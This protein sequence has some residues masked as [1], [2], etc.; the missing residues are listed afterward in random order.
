MEV[1]IETLAS[2]EVHPSSWD[3]WMIN[4]TALAEAQMFHPPWEQRDKKYIY[5]PTASLNNLKICTIEILH[6][7]N[8]MTQDQPLH[9]DVV[10]S[11]PPSFT[12]N[13]KSEAPV[14]P[15]AHKRQW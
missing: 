1:P 10:V 3:V 11:C 8:L 4:G 5:A 2:N 6:A 15:S 7:T 13:L 9:R 12:Q 14:E